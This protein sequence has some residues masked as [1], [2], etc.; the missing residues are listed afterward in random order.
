LA[1]AQVLEQKQKIVS[2]LAE[3]M[4]NAVAGVIV[5]YKGINVE[6]DTKLRAELRK[7]G[8]EYSVVKNTLTARACDEIG[9]GKLKEV[10]TGMTALAISEKDPV[11]AAKIINEYASKHDNYVIKAGFVE[12]EVITPAGVKE[13]AEI[14]GFETLIARLMGSL[15]SSLYNLAYVLQA[16]VDKNGEGAQ[17]GAAAAA[18]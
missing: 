6:D 10:L 4:K 3:K 17:A 15:Q 9:Y 14:P 5:D 16:I 7:A 2:E 18:E 11:V 8:V 12:G 13:L 1:N